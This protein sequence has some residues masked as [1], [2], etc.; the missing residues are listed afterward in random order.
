[1]IM[2]AKQQ[3]NNILRTKSREEKAPISGTQLAKGVS[4]GAHQ[5]LQEETAPKIQRNQI[6]ANRHKKPLYFCEIVRIKIRETLVL[7]INSSDF[8]YN[9]IH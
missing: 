4:E 3:H 8:I 5:L 6:A 2:V 1:M 7:S 9:S